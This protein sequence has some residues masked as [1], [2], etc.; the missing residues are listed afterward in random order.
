MTGIDCVWKA[1]YQDFILC[2]W[3][4]DKISSTKLF[5]LGKYSSN[6]IFANLSFLLYSNYSSFKNFKNDLEK[7][8]FIWEKHDILK[9]EKFNKVVFALKYLN[10]R[11]VLNCFFLLKTVVTF[12]E[13]DL[14]K[15]ISFLCWSIDMIKGLSFHSC[16]G[17]I[18]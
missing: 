18:G 3:P 2:H 6:F 7:R 8:T 17:E 13:E 1:L 15:R 16:Y 9:K 5:K 11:K 12:E 4:Y 10:W 14:T